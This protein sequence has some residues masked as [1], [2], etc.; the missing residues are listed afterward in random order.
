MQEASRVLYQDVQIS[1]TRDW[2]RI[3]SFVTE[4][5]DEVIFNHKSLL[6]L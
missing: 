2:I 1:I 3:P 5:T 6:Q 4:D